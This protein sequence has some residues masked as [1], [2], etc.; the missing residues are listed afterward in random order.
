[1][2]NLVFSYQNAVRLSIW[3]V[4]FCLDQVNLL[5]GRTYVLVLLI[6][7]AYSGIFLQFNFLP[8]DDNIK[9][10]YLGFSTKSTLLSSQYHSPMKNGLMCERDAIITNKLSHPDGGGGKE[11]HKWIGS[12]GCDCS[13]APIMD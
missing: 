8:M 6:R 7:L 13:G 1:M 4:H 10:Q 11:N 12:A 2:V 9:L 5:T 3:F